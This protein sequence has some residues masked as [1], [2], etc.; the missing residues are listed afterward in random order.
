MFTVSFY[1]DIPYWSYESFVEE[2][3]MFLSISITS[4]C[5]V[6]FT[7]KLRQ[8]ESALIILKKCFTTKASK[9]TFFFFNEDGW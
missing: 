2:N 9:L 1:Y 6:H 7:L 4:I 8:V 5:I 3:F